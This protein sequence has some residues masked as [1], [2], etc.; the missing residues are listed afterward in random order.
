[1]PATEYSELNNGKASYA[2]LPIYLF[3]TKYKNKIYQFAMNGQTGKFVGDLPLD[4][5]K[6]FKYSLLV[7]LISFVVLFIAFYFLGMGV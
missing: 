2:L 4:K 3:T 7:F 6:A 1:M 5:S